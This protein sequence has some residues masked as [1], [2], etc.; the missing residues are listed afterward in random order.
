MAKQIKR[1][2][3]SRPARFD[4]ETDAALIKIASD[5]ERE[6]IYYIRKFVKDALKKRGY[7]KPV[8]QQ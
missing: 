3:N 1:Y 2:A 7:I 4:I 8:K 6:P 5:E